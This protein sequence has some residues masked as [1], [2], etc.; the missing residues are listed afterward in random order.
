MSSSDLNEDEHALKRQMLELENQIHHLSR[1]NAEMKEVLATAGSDPDLRSA[2]GENIVAIARQ[3]PHTPLPRPA[4]PSLS[5]PP[6]LVPA[7]ARPSWRT[8]KKS[9]QTSTPLPRL[10]LES[11][12]NLGSPCD[13]HHGSITA[14]FSYVV[15]EACAWTHDRHGVESP[16]RPSQLPGRAEASYSTLC[17]ASWGTNRRGSV[18]KYTCHVRGGLCTFGLR[19]S[20]WE[21]RSHAAGIGDRAH[22][23]TSAIYA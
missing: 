15:H 6:H 20:R 16:G 2:I 13:V 4:C 23:G 19:D 22:A 5:T 21:R 17:D 7:G 11:P 10:R 3:L 9:S 12:V 8:F 18:R 14:T 1:S